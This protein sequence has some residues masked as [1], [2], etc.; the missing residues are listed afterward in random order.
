MSNDARCCCTYARVVGR[1]FNETT[2]PSR[3]TS[4][5]LTHAPD[6]CPTGGANT[7][8]PAHT[9]SGGVIRNV[10][11]LESAERHSPPTVASRPRRYTGASQPRAAIRAIVTDWSHTNYVC[12]CV[13]V[14]ACVCD[15]L[16]C[17]YGVRFTASILP[18]YSYRNNH[19]RRRKASL[20]DRP[21]PASR[22]LEDHRGNI[23]YLKKKL[24]SHFLRLSVQTS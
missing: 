18:I 24:F 10:S 7:R 3:A 17:M 20:W 11:S 14:C 23:F 19:R 4:S 13:F 22:K 15:D 5:D 12:G 1:R 8:R 16:A 6:A 9:R 2:L 21:Q